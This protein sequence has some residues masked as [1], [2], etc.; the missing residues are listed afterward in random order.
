MPLWPPYEPCGRHVTRPTAPPDRD[1][2]VESAPSTPFKPPAGGRRSAGGFQRRRGSHPR[3]QQPPRRRRR[4]VCLQKCSQGC[5]CCNLRYA[6]CGQPVSQ[7]RGRL[8]R[9]RAAHTSSILLHEGQ[10]RGPQNAHF[11]VRRARTRA[12]Q[13]MSRVIGSACNRRDLFRGRLCARQLWARPHAVES[14]ALTPFK[15]ARLPPAFRERLACVC[16]KTV[17]GAEGAAVCLP[18]KVRPSL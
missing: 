16:N 7:Q 1:I 13:R 15:A 12:T 4:R 8:E 9:R 2:A 6:V 18:E 11:F 17:G 10:G 3:T 14:A 5:T